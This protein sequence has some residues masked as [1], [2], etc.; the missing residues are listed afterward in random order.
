MLVPLFFKTMEICVSTL[1]EG[2]VEEKINSGSSEGNGP[3]PE[4]RRLLN[5]REERKNMGRN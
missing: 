5:I 1:M 3:I 4:E 2:D